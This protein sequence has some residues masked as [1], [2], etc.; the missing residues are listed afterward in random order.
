MILYGNN[1]LLQKNYRRIFENCKS[2]N[3]KKKCRKFVWDKK[4][5]NNFNKLKGLLTTAPILKIAYPKKYFVICT[6][7]CN[8]GLGGVLTQEGHVIAYELRNLKTH[9]KNYTTYDL[10]LVAIIHALKIW[11]HH[12]IGKSFF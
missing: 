9:E 5:E 1:R 8:K 12:L 2:Y 7:A 3:I 10:E 4:C 6:N 11:C